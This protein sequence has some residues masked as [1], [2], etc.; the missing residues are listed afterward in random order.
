MNH[1]AVLVIGGQ[2]ELCRIESVWLPGN[3]KQSDLE[4]P[5]MVKRAKAVRLSLHGCGISTI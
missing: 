1:G 3:G 5:S 4:T 2:R